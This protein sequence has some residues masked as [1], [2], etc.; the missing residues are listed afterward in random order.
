MSK[1]ICDLLVVLIVKKYSVYSVKYI[2][3]G[4]G[5]GADAYKNNHSSYHFLF[6]FPFII[7]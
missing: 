3:W 1:T 7:L 5:P 4:V 6:V 2:F